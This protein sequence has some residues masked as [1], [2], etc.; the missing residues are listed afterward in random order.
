MNKLKQLANLY[1]IAHHPMASDEDM[2]EYLELTDEL[3]QPMLFVLFE[4]LF[5]NKE[6]KTVFKTPSGMLYPME[7]FD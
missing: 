1:A 3:I 4:H 7:E 6:G 2:T 5:T